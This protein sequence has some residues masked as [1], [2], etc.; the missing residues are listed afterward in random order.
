VRVGGLRVDLGSLGP[1]EVREVKAHEV[2]EP[3]FTGVTV[4]HASSSNVKGEGTELG[5]GDR[6]G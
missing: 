3:D 6:D 5:V 4:P 1:G 2:S